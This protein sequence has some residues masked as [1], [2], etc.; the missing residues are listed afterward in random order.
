MLEKLA[1]VACPL[2]GSQGQRRRTWVAAVAGKEQ[3]HAATMEG[4]ALV[5]MGT[6]RF[7]IVAGGNHE[8]KEEIAA[9][10]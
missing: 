9:W 3:M 4:R 1:Q 7:A 5:P 2:T 8:R 6:G 10:G